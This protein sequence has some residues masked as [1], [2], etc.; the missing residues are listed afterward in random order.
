MVEFGF[1]ERGRL[2]RSFEAHDIL[3][4][5]DLTD[6]LPGPCEEPAAFVGIKFSRMG[7]ELVADVL[8]DSKIR[9]DQMLQ[10]TV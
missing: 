6:F 7:D 8:R 4:A 3:N 1:V 9:H 2:C 10:L 5:V